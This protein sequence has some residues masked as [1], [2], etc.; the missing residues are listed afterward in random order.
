MAI[1]SV[2][3]AKAA[4]F[5]LCQTLYASQSP[6]VLVFYGLPGTFESTDIVAVTDVVTSVMRPTMGGNRSREE[7]SQLTV[8]VSIFRPGD[9]TQQ[10]QATE[11][12]YAL[13][14][15]LAQY[16]RSTPN[17]TLSGTSRDVWVESYELTES[18]DPQIIS[19]GRQATIVVSV[20]ALARI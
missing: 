3:A 20:R 1:S 2:S 15:L 10:Q 5:A 11:R 6:E 12:A 14:N 8:V 17:E 9:Q 7:N 16:F 4:L 13:V 19:R 18:D